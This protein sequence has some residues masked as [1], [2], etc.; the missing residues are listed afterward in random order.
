[1]S[2]DMHKVFL[3]IKSDQEHTQEK[4]PVSEPETSE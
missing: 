2:M 1:M 4:Q 3:E